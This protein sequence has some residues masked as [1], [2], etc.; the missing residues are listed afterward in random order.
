MPEE[1]I[2]EESTHR[3]CQESGKTMNGVIKTQDVKDLEK[4][5]LFDK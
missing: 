1:K 4:K 3:W 5:I 2:D